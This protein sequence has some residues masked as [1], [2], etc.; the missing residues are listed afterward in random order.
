MR[1]ANDALCGL[2]AQAREIMNG[3][4]RD[5]AIGALKGLAVRNMV[6]VDLP[7]SSPGFYPIV[8]VHAMALKDLEEA[9]YGHLA[10]DE[11]MT[12]ADVIRCL[13]AQRIWE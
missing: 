5:Y 9:F 11:T 12:A 13:V 3:Y 8:K 10:A 7:A 1:S 2:V 4:G 6:S